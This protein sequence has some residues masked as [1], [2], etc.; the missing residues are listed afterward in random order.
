MEL[1]INNWRKNFYE[2]YEGKWQRVALKGPTSI[3][4]VYFGFSQVDYEP[5]IK[6]GQKQ[7]LL[8]SVSIISVSSS[9]KKDLLHEERMIFTY[10]KSLLYPYQRNYFEAICI[11]SNQLKNACIIQT[12]SISSNLIVKVPIKT[13]WNINIVL[14]SIYSG[15]GHLVL[16]RQCAT[17]WKQ[18]FFHSERNNTN[19][20]FLFPGVV[21][22]LR[23]GIF[24]ESDY[25]NKNITTKKKITI[26]AIIVVLRFRT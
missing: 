26:T 16:D 12:I 6:K 15:F 19:S 25:A 18:V 21:S 17:F 10:T 2:G 4:S 22:R 23:G 20:L 7:L 5:K 1:K 13:F 11:K 9:S 8:R 3:R 14:Y 24:L